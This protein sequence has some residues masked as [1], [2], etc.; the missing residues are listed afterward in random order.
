MVLL[1]NILLAPDLFL[2]RDRGTACGVYCEHRGGALIPLI[3]L[4]ELQQ[5]CER[6]SILWP[7]YVMDG[8]KRTRNLSLFLNNSSME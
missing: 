4:P 1:L 3:P 7:P 6:G 2:F 5:L 8:G